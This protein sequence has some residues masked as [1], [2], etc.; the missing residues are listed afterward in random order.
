MTILSV[1]YQINDHIF[2]EH[3]SVLSCS[4]E[5]LSNIVHT[6]S[7]HMEDWCIYG[8]SD[9]CAIDSRSRFVWDSSKSNLVVDYYMDGSS[10]TVVNQVLHLHLFINNTLS[11]KGG[12][13]MD[14]NWTHL[15]AFK[16]S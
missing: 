8:L 6:V 7:I 12:I 16:V 1:T 4:S 3:L 13:T 14:Q 11:C 2:L 15:F 5:H 10:N 9:I